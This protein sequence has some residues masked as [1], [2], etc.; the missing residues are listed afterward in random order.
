VAVSDDG[1]LYV[2]KVLPAEL[3]KY[4]LKPAYLR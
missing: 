1:I 2:A 4:T 3:V